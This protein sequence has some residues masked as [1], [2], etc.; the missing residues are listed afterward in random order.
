[1]PGEMRVSAPLLSITEIPDI[2]PAEEFTE[3]LPTA[4]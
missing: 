2:I 4:A 3:P 1:M